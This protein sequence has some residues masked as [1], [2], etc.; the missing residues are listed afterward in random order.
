MAQAAVFQPK[1][2]TLPNGITIA[3][4]ENHRVPVVHHMVWYKA[5]AVDEP[6]G[7]SGIAHMLEH[8]MFKGTDKIPPGEFSKIVA[9]LGGQDNAFTGQDY[10][11]YHQTIAAE[12][13]RTMME[14]EADRMQNLH[15]NQEDFAP[16]HQVVQE[17][18]RSRIDNVPSAILREQAQSTLWGQHPY[19]NPVIG[20][21]Q[22]MQ[23]YTLAKVRAFHDAWYAPNNAIV[24]VAGD[25]DP[26]AVFA[27]AKDTY[28]RVPARRDIETDLAQRPAFPA[29]GP[30]THSRVEMQHPNATDIA[31]GKSYIAESYGH[32]TATKTP[33]ALQ[34]LAQILGGGFSS[35]LYQDF[36]V[37]TPT[38]LSVGAWYGPASRSYGTFG[39]YATLAVD[40]DVSAFEAK[41]TAMLADL[42]KNGITADELQ[43]AKTR[44][45]ADTIY[46]QDSLKTG[47]NLIGKTLAMGLPLDTVEDWQS[48]MEAITA[49]DVQAAAKALF[50]ARQGPV[51]RSVTTVLRPQAP[52]LAPKP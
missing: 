13:L 34:I 20:W 11:A 6:I 21:P 38:A 9:R 39:L 40:A 14:M 8:M 25:V 26:D 48:H 19:H 51:G 4:I 1:I 37:R 18:R 49:Q 16:E 35:R 41:I 23:A 50:K 12:H 24:V 22:E 32:H 15:I 42:A 10:T 43:R 44:L 29:I 30:L 17:E 36:V 5:G 46:A 31:W 47:A 28:G 52:V 45:K 7:V 2:T 3:V 27:M 33:Y